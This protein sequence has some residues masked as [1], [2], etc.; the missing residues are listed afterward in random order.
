MYYIYLYIYSCMC[1]HTS[2]GEVTLP[3]CPCAKYPMSALHTTQ[4]QPHPHFL[5]CISRFRNCTFSSRPLAQALP[6]SA[7]G[8]AFSGPPRSSF[9]SEEEVAAQEANCKPTSSSWSGGKAE[10]PALLPARA[11][12]WSP[13]TAANSVR[14]FLNQSVG[15]SILGSL[16]SPSVTA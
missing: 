5:T 14:P 6:L 11:A 13:G 9:R 15:M 3:A 16:Y 1:V 8:T 12:S 2:E 4:T 10:R 7:T